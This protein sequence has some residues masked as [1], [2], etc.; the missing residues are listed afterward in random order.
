MRAERSRVYCRRWMADVDHII[1]LVRIT[2]F[3]IYNNRFAFPFFFVG[4][5]HSFPLCGEAAC[6]YVALLI[7]LFQYS[8]I[9]VDVKSLAKFDWYHLSISRLAWQIFFGTPNERQKRKR[10]KVNM[11]SG[12]SNYTTDC[13]KWIQYILR[14]LFSHS[15]TPFISLYS[16]EC[17]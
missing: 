6:L 17:V 14:R 7:T 8:A 3:S 13:N 9:V 11:L 2:W 10:K 1:K 4:T 5:F 12:R 15:L 16:P